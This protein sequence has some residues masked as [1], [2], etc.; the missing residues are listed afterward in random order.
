MLA[1]VRVRNRIERPGPHVKTGQPEQ[2]GNE[3]QGHQRNAAHGRS[4]DAANHHTP[5]AAGQMPDHENR[6]RSQGHPQP[7]HETEQ[8]GTEEL[9]R[10]HPGQDRRDGGENQTDPERSPPDGLQHLRRRQVH[11]VQGGGAHF[12]SSAAG[13]ADS[14]TGTGK[15]APDPGSSKRKAPEGTV[16]PAG[17]S[18]IVASWLNCRTL[19]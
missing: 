1:K 18:A 7:G 14:G 16:C 13:E 17:T 10:A 9:V 2:E 15:V 5:S 4:H 12:D 19:I 8:V 6:H 11:R 3:Q